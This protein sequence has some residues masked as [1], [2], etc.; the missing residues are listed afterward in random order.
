MP[1]WRAVDVQP[2][3][4]KRGTQAVGGH[5]LLLVP[6]FTGSSACTVLFVALAMALL[7]F[8]ALVPMKVMRLSNMITRQ[9]DTY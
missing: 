2:Q 3:P 1:A 7:V 6:T 9:H 8:N 4:P 5:P